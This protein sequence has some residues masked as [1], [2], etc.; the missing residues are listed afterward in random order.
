VTARSVDD[1]EGVDPTTTG[2]RCGAG[3]ASGGVIG[4][5]SFLAGGV[6][7]ALF[8]ARFDDVT[9]YQTGSLP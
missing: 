7:T 4:F 2:A 8:K 3:A 6:T 1:N 5:H 9:A